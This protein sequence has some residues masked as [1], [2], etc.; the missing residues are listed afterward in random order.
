MTAFPTTSCVEDNLRKQI[1]CNVALN[2]SYIEAVGFDLSYTLAQFNEKLSKIAFESA[3]DILAA[4]YADQS[5]EDFIS[6]PESIYRGLVID[7]QRG[8]ILKIDRHKYV[9]TAVHGQ[10][11][12]PAEQR[13]AI[14]NTEVASYSESNF[15]NIDSAHLLVAA[16]LFTC[17]VDWADQRASPAPSSYAAIYRDVK[18]AVDRTVGDD[19]AVTAAVM[20][21]PGEYLEGDAGAVV[22]TL[23]RLRG[24][25]K[26][27]FLL[28]NNLYEYTN[29][30]LKHITHSSDV[31][32]RDLF[33]LVVV[34]AHK[35]DY[36]VNPYLSMFQVDSAGT[37]HN[38]EYNESIDHDALKTLQQDRKHIFQGGNWQDLHRMLGVKYGD[39]ILY[40]ANHMFN[41]ILRSKRTLGWRTCLI[42]PE[43]ERETLTAYRERD[44]FAEERRLYELQIQHDA[45]LDDV[46]QRFECGETTQQDL[47]AALDQA[48]QIKQDLR[49]ASLAYDEKFNVLWGQMFKVG[50]HDSR[51]AKQVRN[52]A[53]LY[54]SKVANLLHVSPNKTFRPVEDLLPHEQLQSAGDIE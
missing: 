13:R 36:L 34:G 18:A 16:Q 22:Q 24:A 43:L 42:V 28:T 50:I 27:T 46:V 9:R 45:E 41:D 23:Q 53:C 31:D 39:K 8:N 54:T 44:L 20:K 10:E 17:I 3:R 49:A 38:L 19:G 40:V 52:Y 30:V 35:P 47:T 32:W 26:K 1:Y 37:L 51:F 4:Q 2:G 14:Y 33:D 7:Q 5:I 12:L 11:I 6:R 25:G 29:V 48:E 21:N 15:V